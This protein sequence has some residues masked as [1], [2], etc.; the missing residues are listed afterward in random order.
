MMDGRGARLVWSSAT[1]WAIAG[2]SST[3]WWAGHFVGNQVG[4]R[5]F[6]MESSSISG[7]SE[8]CKVN[9]NVTRTLCNYRELLL[10]WFRAKGAFSSG[11]VEI[12]LCSYIWDNRFLA[13]H[14]IHPPITNSLINVKGNPQNM[15]GGPLCCPGGGHD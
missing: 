12:P 9:L 14:I 2:R 4:Q 10:N 1:S 3:R 15:I 11:V 8:R 13:C 6:A 7:V 5:R